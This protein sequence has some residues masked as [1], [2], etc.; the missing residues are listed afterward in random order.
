MSSNF[1]SIQRWKIP[2]IS[3][4]NATGTPLVKEAHVL[5]S[6]TGVLCSRLFKCRPPQLANTLQH[7]LENDMATSRTFTE[8]TSLQD[9]LATFRKL[10]Q[11]DVLLD[12]TIRVSYFITHERI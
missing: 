2:L 12:T 5:H 1:A 4:E 3:F 10:R 6:S 9:V 8:N 7:S 11:D